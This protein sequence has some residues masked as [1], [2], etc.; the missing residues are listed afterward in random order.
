M[1]DGFGA[2]LWPPIGT[3]L[4]DSVP[5]GTITDAEPHMMRSAAYAIACRPE[6]QKRFTV[7]A[8]ALTGIPARKLAMRAT[9]IPCSASGIA[10]PRI[11]S[12]ISAGSMPGARFSASAIAIAPSSSGRVPRSVPPGALPEAVR[13][14]ETITAS[15]IIPQQIL[16]RVGDLGH[17]AVEQMIRGVDDNELLRFR[18]ARIERAHVLQEAQLVELALDEEFRLRAARDGVEVVARDR[19]R[20]PDERRH[21]R[22][23]RADRHRDPRAERHPAGPQRRAGILRL[24]VVERRAEVVLLA[25]AVGECAPTGA[26]AAEVEAQDRAADPAERLR[27]LIH[28]LRVH[29]AAELRVRMGEDDRRAQSAGMTRA[30]AAVVADGARRQRFVEDRLEPP[31][32]SRN[33][34]LRHDADFL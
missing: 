15:F 18:G 29:R 30:H 10:Q 20:D 13:T 32:R 3:R 25:G 6:E 26:G 9:F 2:I 24:H 1:S 17:L 33:L 8:D 23:L 19:R 12:S 14:A 7:T 28:D 11:T 21:A 27:G 22:I 16:D 4:I 34:T 5:P 31:G